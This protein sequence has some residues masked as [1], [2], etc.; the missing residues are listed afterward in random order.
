MSEKYSSATP[1]NHQ[2]LKLE[3]VF[4]LIDQLS[5]ED[6]VQILRHLLGGLSEETG[7]HRLSSS[8]IRQIN[9]MDESGLGEVLRA[10]AGRLTLGLLVLLSMALMEFV[11]NAEQE[12][13]LTLTADE[14]RPSFQ[15]AQ[16]NGGRPKGSGA[17]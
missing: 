1:A 17:M 2:M 10:I 3:E 15:I 13:K 8:V 16:M 12:R 4:A 9:R 6:R 7:N 5:V 11:G 14:A